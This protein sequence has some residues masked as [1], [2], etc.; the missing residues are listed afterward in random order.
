MLGAGSGQHRRHVRGGQFGHQH[1]PQVRARHRRTCAVWALM[2]A[3]SEARETSQP[4]AASIASPRVAADKR[5]R[6]WLPPARLAWTRLRRDLDAADD[7][8]AAATAGVGLLLSA[9]GKVAVAAR[10]PHARMA[11]LAGLGERK[12]NPATG[13]V[14]TVARASNTAETPACTWY[15]P[16][17]TPSPRWPATSATI[18]VRL[19][20][21][22]T[23]SSSS[24]PA[25]RSTRLPASTSMSSI[26]GS[27]SPDFCPP[28]RAARHAQVRETRP[29]RDIA[30]DDPERAG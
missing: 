2:E 7:D 27:G 19:P 11:E 6:R 15:R 5:R 25:R 22:L 18:P 20:P 3:A 23:C 4:P 16:G 26:R 13:P 30:V 1:L 10:V 21:R 24:W 12:V 9:L 17:P 28:G 8:E 29:V 14:C